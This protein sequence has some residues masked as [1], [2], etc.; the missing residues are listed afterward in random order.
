MSN[1]IWSLSQEFC[2]NFQKKSCNK[3]MY[4]IQDQFLKGVQGDMSIFQWI[5]L[6][7]LVPSLLICVGVHGRPEGSLEKKERIYFD[8]LCAVLPTY[9]K[10]AKVFRL[11]KIY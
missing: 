2:Q 3:Q 10:G 6:C 8:F 4:N 7:C 9:L 11:K 5:I 1:K